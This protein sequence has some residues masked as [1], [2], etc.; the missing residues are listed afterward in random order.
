MQRKVS[1]LISSVAPSA[2]T[3]ALLGSCPQEVDPVWAI[4]WMAVPLNATNTQ[5]CPGEVGIVTGTYA[6]LLGM[7]SCGLLKA[8]CMLIYIFYVCLYTYIHT[9][10]K[11]CIFA[12]DNSIYSTSLCL[13][14]HLLHHTC[15][16]LVDVLYAGAIL[17]LGSLGVYTALYCSV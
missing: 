6:C 5:R 12:Q 7:S 8:L 17:Q 11:C 4:E 2:V 14:R 16:V 1:L 9:V 3:L 15:I 13:E 10:H